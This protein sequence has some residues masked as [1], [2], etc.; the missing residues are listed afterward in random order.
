MI[1]MPRED[2]YLLMK[3]VKKYAKDKRVLDMGSGSG[4]IT[5]TALNAGAEHVLAVE[6]DEEAVSYLKKKFKGNKKVKVRKSDLF[7]NIKQDEEF[8]V[9]AFNPPYLPKDKHDE[10]KDTTGGKLGDETIIRFL[11]AIKK[12]L[13]RDGIALIVLS[14][15]TPFGR[16]DDLIIKSKI[17]KRKL[18]EKN[19]FFEKIEVWL[20][21]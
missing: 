12:Y 16:I 17:K 5:E 10:G 2:S 3:E 8:D 18:S 1:Y 15:L 7:S 14:S 13:S 20:V 9:I 11:R 19:F 21:H 4:I 6:L